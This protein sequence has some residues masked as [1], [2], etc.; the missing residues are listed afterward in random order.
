MHVPY[1]QLEGPS[2]NVEIFGIKLLG[3]DAQNERKL[4]FTACFFV[5]LYLISKV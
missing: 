1:F 5:I 2:H 3:V 4:L